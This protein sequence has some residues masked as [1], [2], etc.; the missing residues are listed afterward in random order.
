[1]INLKDKMMLKNLNLNQRQKSTSCDNLLRR[2]N[3]WFLHPYGWINKKHSPKIYWPLCWMW[4]LDSKPGSQAWQSNRVA[5]KERFHP[6]K[7]GCLATM[8]GP[9]RAT[10][11]ALPVITVL[12]SAKT[13]LKMQIFFS[14][15]SHPNTVLQ[16]FPFPSLARND[17]I[18]F[19]GSNRIRELWNPLGHQ[20]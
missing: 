20:H 1:M 10:G 3:S 13:T 11:G 8:H 4:P 15:N 19:T 17:G 14:L 6:G 16:V 18:F 9:T 2:S 5:I 7:W 12:S